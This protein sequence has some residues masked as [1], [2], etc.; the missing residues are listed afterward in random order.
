MAGRV[1]NAVLP[2]AVGVVSGFA[3]YLRTGRDHSPV[4]GVNVRDAN[5]DRLRDPLLGGRRA[6]SVRG[7]GNDQRAVAGAELSS[8]VTDLNALGETEDPGQPLHGCTDIVVGD[9]RKHRIGRNG[10]VTDV[11]DTIVFG[12]A[13]DGKVPPFGGRLSGLWG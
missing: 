9:D 2:L 10:G 12:R 13:L 3:Y 1:T 8:V 6:A 11:H 7:V 4:V 5:H